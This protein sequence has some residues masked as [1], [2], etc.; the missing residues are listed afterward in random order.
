MAK[1]I[2]CAYG[3]FAVFIPMTFPLESISG[4]PEFPGFIA[5]SVW[6]NSRIPFSN[7]SF[8]FSELIIPAVIVGPPVKPNGFPI[9]ITI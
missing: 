6:I 7:C 4:P 2:P 1:P 9:A 8:L 3:I 5:A